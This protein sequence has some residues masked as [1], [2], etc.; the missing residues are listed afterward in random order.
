MVVVPEKVSNRS[1][2]W[3]DFR[4][5]HLLTDKEFEIVLFSIVAVVE[6]GPAL[7]DSHH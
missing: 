4:Q 5:R 2:S 6:K 1:L 7:P 3:R